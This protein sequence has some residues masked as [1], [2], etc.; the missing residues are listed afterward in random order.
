MNIRFVKAMAFICT[1][2]L[3]LTGCMS[4]FPEMTDEE[5]DQVVQYSASLLMKNSNN[6]VEKLSSISAY[7]MEKQLEKEARAAAK[8]ERDAAL[9]EQTAGEETGAE[10][11]AS[12]ETADAAETDLAMADTTD[13]AEEDPEE[14]SGTTEEESTDSTDAG[15][16]DDIDALLDEY[17]DTL[18]QGIENA[19]SGTDSSEEESAKSEEEQ[20]LEEQLDDLSS[21]ET[22][23]D[24]SA[25]GSADTSETDEGSSEELTTETDTEV[26]GMRQELT[27]GLFLTYSGYSVAGSYADEDDVFS[28]TATS[29]NKLLVLNFQL[30]NTSDMDVSIDMVK[31]NPHFQVLLNDTNVG[32]TNVTMLEDDLSSFAGTIPAKGK[33]N[34]VLI[35]QMKAEKVKTIDSLGLIG[36]LGDETITFNLE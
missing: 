27:N 21:S 13:T 23:N 35:K 16:E 3:F 14:A 6:G 29:G 15:S 17:G 8:A 22:V 19:Q 28:I 31:A 24:G 25:E 12:G 36:T 9:E 33:Q 5:Y 7:E 10:D 18:D 20:T 26:D 4:A 30:V 34:M 1:T 11:I 2:G 32:Y